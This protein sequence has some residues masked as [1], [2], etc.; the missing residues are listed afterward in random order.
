MSELTIKKDINISR[1]VKYLNTEVTE[2]T[3][4]VKHLALVCM[5]YAIAASMGICSTRIS[6]TDLHS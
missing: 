5:V 4:C 1:D 6:V 3:A 2:L